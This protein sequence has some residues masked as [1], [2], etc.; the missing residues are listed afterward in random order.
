MLCEGHMHQL[1]VVGDGRAGPSEISAALA[2]QFEVRFHPLDAV[3]DVAPGLHTLIDINL[4][5]AAQ[6]LAVKE[7]LN[8]KPKDA[9]IVFVTSKASRLQEARAAALGGTGTIHH[10]IDRLT[11]LSKLRDGDAV[12]ETVPSSEKELTGGVATATD[13]LQ[14]I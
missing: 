6:L 8:R 10:P 5:D 14:S 2:A 7:W 1:I 4:D 9:K 3:S 11:L 13:A 12:L